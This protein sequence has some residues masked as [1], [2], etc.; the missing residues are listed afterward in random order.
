[1]FW[2][3]F[4][5]GGLELNRVWVGGLHQQTREKL[6]LH[7]GQRVVIFLGGFERKDRFDLAFELNDFSSQKLI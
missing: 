7:F 4:I 2:W 1:V 3:F 6:L 5:R